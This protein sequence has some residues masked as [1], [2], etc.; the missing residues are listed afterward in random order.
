M[1]H[2][3]KGTL[4]VTAELALLADPAFDQCAQYWLYY[5]KQLTRNY[6]AAKAEVAQ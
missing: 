5:D 1:T 3:V 4:A 2:V 6:A